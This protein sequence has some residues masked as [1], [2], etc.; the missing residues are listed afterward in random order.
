MG[1]GGR[2]W[3]W[4]WYLWV[5]GVSLTI[6]AWLK[7]GGG[8]GRQVGGAGESQTMAPSR[9]CPPWTKYGCRNFHKE[10]GLKPRTARVACLSSEYNVRTAPGITN[11]VRTR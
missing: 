11:A 3:P 7:G 2:I 1:W 4:G 9:H 8:G 5:D 10:S 6:R